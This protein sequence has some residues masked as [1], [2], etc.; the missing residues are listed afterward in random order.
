MGDLALYGCY[1]LNLSYS[2]VEEARR[3]E[4]IERCYWPLLEMVRDLD[5]SVGI[6]ASALTLEQAAERDPGWVE[7]LRELCTGGPCTFVGSGYVQLIG[8]LVPPEVN[9]A[10]QVAGTERYEALLGFR[11]RIALV[12]EQ[13]FSAG[14]VRHYLDAGYRAI[15]M[16]WDN[17]AE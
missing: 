15:V 13:T 1:H 16:E 9:R 4:V 7:A 17:P 6:E 11:P 3:A 12:N 5:L 10:N 14:M 8:P 2:S